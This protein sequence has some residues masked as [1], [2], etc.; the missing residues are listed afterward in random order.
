M[1]ESFLIT[2]RE[3]VEATLIVG[4]VFVYLKTI[5]KEHLKPY[6]YSGVVLAVLASVIGAII[7]NILYHGQ[8]TR[9]QQIFE[10][11]IMLIAAIFV[12][13]MILWMWRSARYMK[14]N[15]EGGIDRALQSKVT[16][17]GI[18]LFVFLTV[19]REGAETVLFLYAT[20]LQ[21][22]FL[23]NLTGGILGVVLA[24]LFGFLVI[25][26]S[27]HL[28]LK[29]FFTIT[30]FFLLFFTNELIAKSIHEFQEARLLAP[31]STGMFWDIQI[32]LAS[33]N[34]DLWTL[35]PI[36]LIP[37]LLLLF[38][39]R[40]IENAE[41]ASAQSYVL[42]KLFAGAVTIFVVL[43][44][45]SG[46]AARESGYNPLPI[47][48]VAPFT[49]AVRIPIQEVND[50]VTK[51]TV[52]VRGVDVRFFLIKASDGIVKSALDACRICGPMGFEQIGTTV[53]CQRCGVGMEIDEIGEDAGCNP[54]PLESFRDGDEIVIPLESFL[55]DIRIWTEY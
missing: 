41:S 30:G 24:V 27:I 38:A 20:S 6:L 53:V 43:I 11:T 40:K 9:G 49:D 47:H 14:K 34:S 32:W 42:T 3:T 2:L 54:I 26:G 44:T 5:K 55:K 18:L 31:A 17:I 12:V 50:R 35:L 13:T 1:S 45:L 21:S 52:T 33:P 7:L 15:I 29:K 51:Y 19:F 48:I 37:S 4:I 36:V 46:V 25:Q 23:S 22:S 28:D 10:G 16:G 8:E 39:T